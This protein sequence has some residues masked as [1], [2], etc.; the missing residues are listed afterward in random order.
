MRENTTY[1]TALWEETL[2]PKN[3]PTQRRKSKAASDA[4]QSSALAI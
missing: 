3:K 1:T 4:N 2:F